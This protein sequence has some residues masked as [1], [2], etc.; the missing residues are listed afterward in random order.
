MVFAACALADRNI[1]SEL[2]VEAFGILYLPAARGHTPDPDYQI[3]GS[4][5]D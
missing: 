5:A 1:V 3:F 2:F 4:F